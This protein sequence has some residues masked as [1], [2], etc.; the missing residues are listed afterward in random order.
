M[1]RFLLPLCLGSIRSEV[2][3]SFG[4]GGSMGAGPFLVVW[5]RGGDPVGGW[6]FLLAFSAADAVWCVCAVRGIVF[7]WLCGG[8][9]GVWSVF[10]I[11]GCIGVPHRMCSLWARSSGGQGSR[12][13]GSGIFVLA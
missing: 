7:S 9:V 3:V 1:A 6:V 12:G 13:R 11:S 4:V 10:G 8:I 2:T 5:D